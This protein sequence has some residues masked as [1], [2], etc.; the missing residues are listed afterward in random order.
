MA[1]VVLDESGHQLAD[2]L[3]ALQ[4]TNYTSRIPDSCIPS[5]L[6]YLAESASMDYSKIMTGILVNCVKF[7]RRIA[8]PA[9]DIEQERLRE[10][11]R[12]EL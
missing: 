6:E 5:V 3:K 7:N 11:E 10:F 4:D 8:R 12:N 1:R 2:I 9:L